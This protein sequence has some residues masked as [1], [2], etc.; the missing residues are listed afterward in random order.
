MNKGDGIF[1]FLWDV[2]ANMTAFSFVK[3]DVFQETISMNFF[4]ASVP[5]L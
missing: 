5:D 4:A 1:I 2:V 3:E